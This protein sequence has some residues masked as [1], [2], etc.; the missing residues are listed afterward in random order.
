MANS[1]CDVRLY[2]IFVLGLAFMFIF[3]AFQTCSMAEKA[4]LTSA[5]NGTFEG[6]GY[7][8]LGIIYAVFGVSNWGAP[9]F[10][11]FAG[12]KVSMVFGSTLYFV[13]ILSFLKPMV[14]ALYAGSALVGIGAAI[15]WTAQG[16]FLTIN[17]ESA[18]IG[19]N[20]G[21]FWALLQS[22]LLFGNMYSYF[23]FRGEDTISDSSRTHLFIGLSGAGL[24]GILLLLFLR[25][26]RISS[27]DDS[28]VSLN[29]SATQAPDLPL[30]ALKRAFQLLRTKEMLVLSVAFAYTG[31]EL[32]FFS[33]VYGTCIAQNKHFGEDRK[34]LLGISG[35]MIGAGEIIGGGAFGLFGKR[36]N[37]FGRDPIVVLGYF[38]HMA[39][40]YIS[41]INLPMDSPIQETDGPT[42]F[43]S[44]VVLALLCSFLLGF[45]DASFNTQIYSLIGFVFSED[46]SP[47][48]ALF[49]FVQSVAAAVAFYYSNVL[50]LKWQLVILVAM[51]TGSVMCFSA[52]EWDATRHAR[53]GYQ[54][55]GETSS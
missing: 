7:T 35:M 24:L 12:P 53:S 28:I 8:S 38:L 21:I 52:I 45:G 5:Y 19:R 29:A 46:S 39:A 50:L 55:I 25:K 44:S 49:K 36:T 3:T 15:L 17:S 47:A 43:E 40:F 42:Y 27:S 48:F 31:L 16:N 11:S 37:K 2:N 14:W 26:K 1:V 6:N 20:S 22:S 32:T 10:V 13:F 34:G 33:G 4:V 23:V 51:G 9:S 30:T 18:T 54:P 41:F